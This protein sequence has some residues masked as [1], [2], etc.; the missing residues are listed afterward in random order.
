VIIVPLV[1]PIR[2]GRVIELIKHVI[3]K[4]L[5]AGRSHV[6]QHLGD[7]AGPVIAVGKVHRRPDCDLLRSIALVSR[8]GEGQAVAVGEG[9]DIA[10]GVIGDIGSERLEDVPS[11]GLPDL[12]DLS[13][14]VAVRFIIDVAAGGILNDVEV[15]GGVII[16]SGVIDMIEDILV[17][18]AYPALGV[19]GV[20]EVAGIGIRGQNGHRAQPAHFIG[21]VK[22]A[23]RRAAGAVIRVLH[24]GV[25]GIVNVGEAVE[26]KMLD[27]REIRLEINH[28][29][30]RSGRIALS[31]M[32]GSDHNYVFNSVKKI[33][34][35]A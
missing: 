28:G 33:I 34:G 25:G 14:V 20:A 2:A 16:I 32:L 31:V 9:F 12:A 8:D 15:A 1:S 27:L 4:G 22:T 21:R 10:E 30:K 35:Y 26:V 13:R 3:V 24:V 18:P 29:E 23:R 7:V 17:G 6:V 5:I 19:V 11:D